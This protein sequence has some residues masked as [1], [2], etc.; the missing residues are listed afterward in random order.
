MPVQSRRR[1]VGKPDNVTTVS[2]VANQ[3]IDMAEHVVHSGDQSLSCF[4][5]AQ[6]P[7][8]VDKVCALTEASP[9]VCEEFSKILGDSVLVRV[10]RKVMMDG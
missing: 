1:E 8:H 9:E 7:S 6:I 4:D 5:L 2:V 3:H 10:M